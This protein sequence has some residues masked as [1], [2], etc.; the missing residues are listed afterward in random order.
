MSRFVAATIN[1]TLVN[2]VSDRSLRLIASAESATRCFR[3]GSWLAFPFALQFQTV[4]SSPGAWICVGHEGLLGS[5]TFMVK[6]G[7]RIICLTWAHRCTRF[8][9]PPRPCPSPRR[10]QH[11]PT[12]AV[13]RGTHGERSAGAEPGRCRDGRARPRLVGLTPIKARIR[14]IAALLV[15]DK[16]RMNL[17]L[18]A[19]APA[20]T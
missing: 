8:P 10:A 6:A 5:G 17:G 7:A 13:D 4:G 12:P 2:N 15:I 11:Q 20:C 14:D 19:Q 18:Q 1:A 9:A 3:D 16:L